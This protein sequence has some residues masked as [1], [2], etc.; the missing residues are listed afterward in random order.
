M[1]E[2]KQEPADSK[3]QQEPGGGKDQQKPGGGQG[4]AGSRNRPRSSRNQEVA[5]EQQES[6]SSQE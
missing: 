2:E 4:G 6:G 5:E 1:A 3:E